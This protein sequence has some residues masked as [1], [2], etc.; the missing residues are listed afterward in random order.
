MNTSLTCP[1]KALDEI[2]VS[3]RWEWS[4]KSAVSPAP[5]QGCQDALFHG[6]GRSQFGARS[7]L[8]VREHGKIWRTLLAAPS[9]RLRTCFFNIPRKVLFTS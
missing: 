6:Q 8:T 4:K 3:S 7:V 5:T 1:I 2:D 9:T